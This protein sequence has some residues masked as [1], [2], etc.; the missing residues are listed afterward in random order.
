MVCPNLFLIQVIFT[1]DGID[2]SGSTTLKIQLYI[3]I[4]LI[5]ITAIVFLD[6][7]DHNIIRNI[8]LISEDYT[9]VSAAIGFSPLFD[10]STSFTAD[11]NLIQHNLITKAGLGILVQGSDIQNAKGNRIVANII[12]DESDSLIT[13]GINLDH[14][15]NTLVENNTVQ[16]LEHISYLDFFHDGIHGIR[17][18]RTNGTVIRNNVVRNINDPFINTYNTHHGSAGI[19]I[20]GW[21]NE[22]GNNNLVY[23]NLVYD[24]R[25]GEDQNMSCAAGINIWYQNNP[26]IYYNS[27]YLDN[28]GSSPSRSAAL[29]IDEACTNVEVKN[30]IFV[31]TRNESWLLCICNL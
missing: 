25:H 3:I 2:L 30:N 15:E 26:K 22:Y 10:F 12:G 27:V 31:N 17:A 5:R 23:N 16:N 18:N 14:T 1:L 24:I 28:T 6:N 7:S 8:T 19:V 20:S 21:G 9:K 11:S 13:W 4:N 29:N